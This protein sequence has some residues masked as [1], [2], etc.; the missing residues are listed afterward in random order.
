MLRALP[1]AAVLAV[2]VTVAFGGRT[3]AA[4]AGACRVQMHGF[5]YHQFGHGWEADTTVDTAMP[6]GSL[7]VGSTYPQ[8]RRNK[9][10][11]HLKRVLPDCQV[12]AT[13][14]ATFPSDH[15]EIDTI[16]ST[17]DGRILVVGGGDSGFYGKTAFVGRFS[18]DLR[19]DRSF[20]HHGWVRFVPPGTPRGT[21]RYAE[22]SSVE[23][24]PSGTIVLGGIEN[25]DAQCSDRGFVTELTPDGAP[26][27]AFGHRGSTLI[28]N[29][30]CT[31]IYGEEIGINP[32]LSLYALGEHPDICLPPPVV[33]VF[34]NGVLD[35]RFDRTVAR[36]I[37]RLMRPH[38]PW[39]FLPSLV[40]DGKG[41]ST[42]VGAR[43]KACGS[44]WEPSAPGDGISMRVAPSGRIVG[45]LTHFKSA[46]SGLDGSVFDSPAALQLPSGR[47]LAGGSSAT[48]ALVQVFAP[49]G[50]RDKTVGDHG[51]L[52]FSNPPGVGDWSPSVD[53]LPATDGGA[54]LVTGFPHEFDVT[55]VGVL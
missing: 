13:L 51:L 47:V 49:D 23:V 10:V 33:H 44:G 18:A 11:L 55:P 45:G 32:D 42:L 34:A 1:V 39:L 29:A 21:G 7:V 54:W 6:D 38:S 12:A 22:V 53:V 15:G 9:I 4:T 35:R 43:D 28:P 30:A 31:Y 41:G 19:L 36:T 2:V 8:A 40:L 14:N 48:N 3:S 20:G 46:N 17:P 24:M 52:A 50:T 5:D 16:A 26:V 27:R 25:A 37:K